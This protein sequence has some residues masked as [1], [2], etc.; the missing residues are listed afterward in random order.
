MS[1]WDSI[2]DSISKNSN[3]LQPAVSTA[4]NLF[5]QY[6]KNNANSNI[7]DYLR[8]REQ[9]NY[10]T[11]K[12]NN[13]AYMQWATENA[14]ASSAK[15]AAAAAAKNAT[16][17]ARQEALRKA[18]GTESKAY[19]KAMGYINPYIEAGKSLLPQRVE[20]AQQGNQLAALLGQY[21]QTPQVQGQIQQAPITNISNVPMQLPDYLLNRG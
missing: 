7:V 21:L 11:S 18:M 9:L 8:Q 4:G 13:D 3:W 10:D 2:T 5:G 16:E 20:N 19:K 17:Q 6:E 1:F 12:A 14:A 15:A